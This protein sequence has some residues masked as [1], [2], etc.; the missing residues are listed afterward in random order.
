VVWIQQ[1]A[2]LPEA[3]APVA[4]L[5]GEALF[6]IK[7]CSGCHLGPG[8]GE[9]VSVGPPLLGLSL[10][11]AERREGMTAEEYVRQSM[12]E[13]QAFVVAGYGVDIQMPTLP[14]T[15]DEVDAIVSFL[16]QQP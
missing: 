6:R 13:P 2:A 15:E 8:I 5:D 1:P 16:L 14:L 11:A 10:V 4:Q 9:G 3:N 12:L 7:G